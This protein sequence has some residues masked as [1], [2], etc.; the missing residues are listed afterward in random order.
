MKNKNLHHG[1]RKHI[2]K[3]QGHCEPRVDLEQKRIYFGSEIYKWK[4][5]DDGWWE[6]EWYR[7]SRHWVLRDGEKIPFVKEKNRSEIDPEDGRD[8]LWKNIRRPIK[9]PGLIGVL[10]DLVEHEEKRQRRREE[11]AERRKEELLRNPVIEEE[12][13]RYEESESLRE[14][15]R[16]EFSSDCE[17]VIK[18]DKHGIRLYSNDGKHFFNIGVYKSRRES[19]SSTVCL[20]VAGRPYVYTLGKSKM[21]AL[22]GEITRTFSVGNL[23]RLVENKRPK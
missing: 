5:D 14:N 9:H 3:H 1:E 12:S 6:N 16:Q 7:Y 15:A 2:H 22:F 10:N 13:T 23:R 21:E 18:R 17:D 11:I 20:F 19:G 4:S 8:I